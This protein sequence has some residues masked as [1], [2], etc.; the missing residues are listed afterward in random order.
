M[1]LY[2]NQSIKKMVITFICF[3]I[4][5]LALTGI[6]TYISRNRIAECKT[7]LYQKAVSFE[8][9]RDFLSAG[10]IYQYLCE[11]AFY[12]DASKPE[13]PCTAAVRS[14]ARFN[15]LT[16]AELLKRKQPDEDVLICHLY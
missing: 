7:G 4:A 15:D 12:P 1:Q 2:N 3:V 16:N 13:H 8:K 11:G 10:N 5:L 6:N 9:E 14:Q